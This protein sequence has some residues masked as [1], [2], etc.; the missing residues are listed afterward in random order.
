MRLDLMLPDLRVPRLSDAL[1]KQPLTQLRQMQ[2]RNEA[3]WGAGGGSKIFNNRKEKLIKRFQ[4]AVNPRDELTK[5]QSTEVGWQRLLLSLYVESHG[6]DWLPKFDVQVA[7]SILGTDASEWNTSRRRQATLLFFE[8]FD[9]LPALSFLANQ[10]RKA[11]S[12][13]A[14]TIAGIGAVWLKERNFIFYPDGP[15]RI[16]K[17]AALNE[18][19]EQLRDRFGVPENGSFSE[20]LRQV[21]LLEKLQRCALGDEPE[22]LQEIERCRA[23]PAIDSLCLGAAALR[24]IVLRVETEGRC[25]WPHAWQ[26]WIV[27]LGCDPRMG[28]HSAEGA[29]W[30]GWATDSQLRIA[31]HGVTGLTLRFFI[32]F[33]EHSL[34]GTEKESQFTLRSRFLLALFEAGKIQDT[35]LCLNW[36]QLQRMK[37]AMAVSEIEQGTY[38]HYI[39]HLS[40]TTDKTSMICLRCTDDIFII[41]GTH[42]FGL[43]VYRGNGRFPITGFWERSRKT[44]QDRELRV[45]RDF[46]PHDQWG[47]WVEKFFGELRWKHH[48]ENNW[49]DVKI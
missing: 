1:L 6:Q 12:I 18:K 3:K 31:Q 22:I 49:R 15:Q 2:E 11:Y 20:K 46:I 9:S 21:Y 7:T 26:R 30:W 44:Y 17:E 48:L 8:R 32:G 33:L 42:T 24:I 41:E 25:S 23:E 40:D 45:G 13:G 35:R 47:R 43:R 5:I 4:G 36:A 14:D 28:R 39:A 34:R 29:K 16:A 27:R 10:L 37:G 38:D 19:W